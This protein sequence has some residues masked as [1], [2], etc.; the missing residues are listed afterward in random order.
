MNDRAHKALGKPEM[1][2]LSYSKDGNTIRIRPIGEDGLNVEKA[3]VFA[4]GFFGHFRIGDE[5][6]F[7]A[8]YDEIDNALYV[9][10]DPPNRQ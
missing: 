7:V 6:R 5:G 1:V 2:E 8:V 9:S 10:L 3:K 4:K